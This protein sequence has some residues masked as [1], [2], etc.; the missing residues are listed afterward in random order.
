MILLVASSPGTPKGLGREAQPPTMR[1]SVRI[2]ILES[3]KGTSSL[4]SARRE[5][6]CRTDISAAT[7]LIGYRL[8]AITLSVHRTEVNK[9]TSVSFGRILKIKTVYGHTSQER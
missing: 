9:T 8:L 5:L 6:L 3:R 4:D 1:Q 7:A 2:A